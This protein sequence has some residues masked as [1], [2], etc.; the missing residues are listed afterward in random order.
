[1]LEMKVIHWLK[2]PYIHFLPKKEKNSW[3]ICD[4]FESPTVDQRLKNTRWGTIVKLTVDNKLFEY[5]FRNF[6]LQKAKYL[7]NSNPTIILQIRM[8]VVK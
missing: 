3:A 1:M 6:Y 4:K 5:K 8:V 2:Y 7:P